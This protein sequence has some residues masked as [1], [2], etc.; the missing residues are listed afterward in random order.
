MCEKAA[1][2]LLR[3]PSRVLPK[4]LCHHHDMGKNSVTD[5]DSD[6]EQV[7]LI[8]MGDILNTSDTDEF[9]TDSL[10]T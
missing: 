1:E 10:F 6:K 2:A 9:Y 7:G 3:A 4:C 5:R 8:D